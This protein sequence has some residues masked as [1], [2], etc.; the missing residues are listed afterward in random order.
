MSWLLGTAMNMWYRCLFEAVLISLDANVPEMGLL[1]HLWTSFPMCPGPPMLIYLMMHQ[2]TFPPT[3][4]RTPS[5]PVS[6]VFPVSSP[7]D[8]SLHPTECETISHWVF[9]YILRSLVIW[10]I[11][12]CFFSSQFYFFSEE[13]LCRSFTCW[14]L[15][16]LSCMNVLYIFG[17]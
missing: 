1:D 5:S 3:L 11:F 7:F 6:P 13:Y 10:N 17:C 8:K 12:T 14:G 4:W 2:S 16:W 9:V 15:L